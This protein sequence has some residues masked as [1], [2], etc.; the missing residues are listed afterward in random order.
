MESGRPFLHEE[1]SHHVLLSG[2]GGVGVSGVSG[3][4]VFG[5]G[6]RRIRRRQGRTLTG[7]HGSRRR[8]GRHVKGR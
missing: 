7:P 1:S 5:D 6:G 4:G 2:R 8:H 3:S